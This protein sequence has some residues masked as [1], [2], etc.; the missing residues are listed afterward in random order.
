MAYRLRASSLP[1]LLLAVISIL[2]FA[3]RIAWIGEPCRSPCRT[4]ADH[5][6]IFDEAYYVNAA[7]VIASVP[8]PAGEHYVGA[9]PGDDP[10]AEHPQLA[11]LEIAGAIELFGD[12]P[13]AWRI[14]SIVLGSLAI[15][16]MFALARAAGAGEWLALG[17]AG[18]MASDNLL[19]V[20][21]RIGTLDIYALTAMIWG[22]V[23][24]LRGRRWIGGAVLGVGAAC[25]LVAPYAVLVLLVFEL[26]R[27]VAG[28]DGWRS[29]VGRRSLVAWR[30]IG[31]RLGGATA[32]GVTTFFAL[33]A[34]MDR[35]APPYDPVAG[36]P[37][38]GGVFHHLGHMIS[39]AAGQTSPR[40]PTGIAS[41]PWEWLVDFKPITYLN[42][43]PSRPS[44]GLEHVHPAALFLGMISPTLMLLALPALVLVAAA[45]ARR[46]RRLACV[47]GGEPLSQVPALGSGQAPVLGL[48]WVLGTLLPF[49][50]LSAFWRRTSYLYYMVI[51]M[52]GI[53]L[54]VAHLALRLRQH[55]WIVGAWAL[56]V[57][58]AAVIMYPFMPLL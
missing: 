39:Y 54:V 11:K 17:A 41:Y 56:S 14:G 8:P 24:Y 52:P 27:E 46:P 42:I 34:V 58:L 10:N 13:F 57:L 9:P 50:V 25:K 23:L 4:A 36:R 37:V 1:V 18:L 5:L 47:L 15:L 49:A 38:A 51:V 7:R 2:S 35:L 44:P 33:L 29:L 6:L 28:H 43:N 22:V 26:L 19:L 30:G 48:A 45:V 21:S 53:Y 16:G 3:A 55:R 31:A 20:H 32:A 12:G 40:G